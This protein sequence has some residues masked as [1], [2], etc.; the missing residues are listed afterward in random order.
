MVLLLFY[1]DWSHTRRLKSHIP[2][3]TRSWNAPA[4]STQ[5]KL[6]TLMTAAFHFSPVVWL[7]VVFSEEQSCR[8][9]PHL[10]LPC[11]DEWKQLLRSITL[12]LQTG[13]CTAPNLKCIL[14]WFLWRDQTFAPDFAPLIDGMNTIASGSLKKVEKIWRESEN[15]DM[16]RLNEVKE[17]KKITVSIF[18]CCCQEDK[19]K[20]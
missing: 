1:F 3:E 2:S 17:R 7:K 4:G 16:A 10:Q 5:V 13:N 9:C 8:S 20:K 12:V 18:T 15:D 11:C 14:P 6:I 19:K